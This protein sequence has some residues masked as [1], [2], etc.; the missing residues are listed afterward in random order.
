[1]KNTKEN[2]KDHS[3]Y[4]DNFTWGK[5][6]LC[7]E[8]AYSKGYIKAPSIARLM[9]MYFDGMALSSSITNVKLVV[10]T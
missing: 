10:M 3:L 1:M 7:A 6:K 8:D 4:C 5:A 2:S 9:F